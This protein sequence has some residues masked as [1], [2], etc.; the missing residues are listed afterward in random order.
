MQK[1]N[2]LIDRFERIEEIANKLASVK[3][4]DWVDQNCLHYDKVQLKNDMVVCVCEDGA[5]VFGAKPFKSGCN[6]FSVTVLC[7]QEYLIL[8][9]VDSALRA[10]N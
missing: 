4:E 1:V 10:E 6:S 9:V 5:E 3:A 8:G 7:M 2:S